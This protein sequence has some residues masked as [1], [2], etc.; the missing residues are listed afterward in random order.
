MLRSEARAKSKERRLP[1]HGVTSQ[2]RSEVGAGSGRKPARLVLKVLALLERRPGRRIR[3]GASRASPALTGILALAVILRRLAGALAGA[4]IYGSSGMFRHWP[5]PQAA[6]KRW[7]R[8]AVMAILA[9][10][11]LV[12]FIFLLA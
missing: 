2:S 12:S 8:P 9:P 6:P 7:G 1:G 11:V 10:D 5:L 4:A 3:S